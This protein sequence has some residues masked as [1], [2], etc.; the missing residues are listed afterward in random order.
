MNA[1]HVDAGLVAHAKIDRAFRELKAA[2]QERDLAATH[3]R[4]RTVD[5]IVRTHLAEE[6]VELERFAALDADEAAA[7]RAEHAEIV[8]RLDELARALGGG[9]LPY[10]ALIAFKTFFTVHEAR[11]ETGFYRHYHGA[12][13]GIP[14]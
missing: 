2:A 3:E 14:R 5:E 4:F 8:R 7:L 10:E 9:D 11:E 1:E 12:G 13:G 6:E